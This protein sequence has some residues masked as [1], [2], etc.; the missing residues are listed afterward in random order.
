[1]G[2]RIVVHSLDQAR[3]ALA[4]AASL[5]R[6]V[7]LASGP[8]AGCYAGP[9]WFKA[10][11]ALAQDSYPEAQMES[12][13]DCGADSGVALAALRQGVKRVGFSGGAEARAKLE[14]IAQAFG[15]TVESGDAP[16]ALDLRDGK[17]AEARCR[18]YLAGGRLA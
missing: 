6:P 17:N 2:G 7:V 10:L 15:A 8:G 11:A 18:A 5:K 1:M 9:S 3:A 14:E 16:D 4:A 12:V 13:L